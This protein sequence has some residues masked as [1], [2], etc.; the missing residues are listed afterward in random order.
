MRNVVG[1]NVKFEVDGKMEIFT[2]DKDIVYFENIFR[3]EHSMKDCV[4]M[5]NVNVSL[6]M[7]Y[8]SIYVDCVEIFDNRF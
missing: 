3:K 8:W 6:Q 1:E 5:S 7:N 2:E 4:T